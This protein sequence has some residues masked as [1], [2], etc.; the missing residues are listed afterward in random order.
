MNRQ[1]FNSLRSRVMKH[2]VVKD[3]AVVVVTAKELDELL[4]LAESNLPKEKCEPGECVGRPTVDNGV[5]SECVKCGSP[6]DM[7]G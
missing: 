3:V 2:Q 6:V 4:D 7:R 5:F 1:Q